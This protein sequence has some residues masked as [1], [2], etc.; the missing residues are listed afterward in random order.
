MS[1]AEVVAD[2]S[3]NSSVRSHNARLRRPIRCITVEPVLF[4]AS[5]CI[6][7]VLPLSQ[8]YIYKRMVDEY[9]PGLVLDTSSCKQSN[10][11]NATFIVEQH[12]SKWMMSFTVSYMIPTFFSSLLLGSLSD[13]YGRKYVLLLPLIGGACRQLINILVI[14]FNLHIE[15]LFIGYV[16]DGIFGGTSIIFMSCFA[17]MSDLTTHENRMLRFVILECCSTVGM[18]IASIGTGYLIR[19][20]GFLWPNVIVLSLLAVNVLYSITLQETAAKQKENSCTYGFGHLLQPLKLYVSNDFSGRRYKLLVMLL[21]F[22]LMNIVDFGRSDC[23]TLHLLSVPFC[24]SS[25]TLGFFSA[26]ARTASVVTSLVLARLAVRWIGDVGLVLFACISGAAYEV[27]FP[28]MTTV[29]ML[30]SGMIDFH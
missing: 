18:I 9:A 17:Y 21:I 24:W 2:A 23:E 3:V 10:L 6:G 29:A 1:S 8:Q 28:F 26:T 12:S 5:I 16:L 11:A 22:V 27:I 15:F 13:K 20:I 25:I 30:F 7:M 19:Y 14:G 4:I